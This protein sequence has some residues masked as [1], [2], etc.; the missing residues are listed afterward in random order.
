MVLVS[1]L[2]MRLLVVYRMWWGVVMDLGDRLV[3]FKGNNEVIIEIFSK[4]SMGLGSNYENWKERGN[5]WNK[6]W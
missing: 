4:E 3:V 6:Y 5:F 1:C 2:I